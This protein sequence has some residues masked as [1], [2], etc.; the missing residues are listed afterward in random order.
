MKKS[1]CCI[2][3]FCGNVHKMDDGRPVDHKCFILPTEALV[4]ERDG[5]MKRSW[6]IMQGWKNRRPHNGL[7]SKDSKIVVQQS[8]EQANQ[9]FEQIG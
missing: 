6:Q 8:V 5:D 7:R 3:S 9:S 1:D 2:A 4:A